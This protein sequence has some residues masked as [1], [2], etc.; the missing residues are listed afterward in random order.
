M[1]VQQEILF[2]IKILLPFLFYKFKRRQNGFWK[3]FVQRKLDQFFCSRTE[4]KIRSLL[5]TIR[6]RGPHNL[7]QTI[8]SPNCIND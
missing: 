5:K 8:Q 2:K 3:H 1:R 7:S 4:S 6:P